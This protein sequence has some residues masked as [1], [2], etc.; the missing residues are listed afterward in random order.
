MTPSFL[1]RELL[2]FGG[3][4]AVS[5]T[6][7]AQGG[8]IMTQIDFE[9]ATVGALPAGITGALT[10]SGAPAAWVV[11]EDATAPAGSKVLAQTSIDKTD[12]RFPLAIFDSPVAADV[13]VA[14]RFRP[15]GGE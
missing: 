9:T 8:G 12:Y 7:R 11:L 4:F 1:R 3:A 10:G 13:D 6:S 15:V 5:S 2:A 14:V